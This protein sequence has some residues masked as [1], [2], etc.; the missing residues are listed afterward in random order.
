MK[1]IFIRHGMTRGNLEHRY[2]GRT[3]EPLLYGYQEKI[4]TDDYP[5]ADIVFTS[6][7]LR[8]RQTAHMIYPDV[9]TVSD[10]RLDEMDFGDFEYKNYHELKDNAAYQRY[11]DSYGKEAFPN[12]ED[13][14]S[15]KNRCKEGFL[16]C[17]NRAESQKCPNVAFVI[18]GGSIM[19]ILEAFAYPAQDYF[20]WQVK[21]NHGFV[22]ELSHRDGINGEVTRLHM[23]K[24]I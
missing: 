13:I 23:V 21:N 11:I 8:S 6:G 22:F 4:N 20:T 2:V 3:D 14:K 9:N 5:A 10:H 12:G 24:E 7:M 17:V 18:H 1:L 19:A 15:F 16:S